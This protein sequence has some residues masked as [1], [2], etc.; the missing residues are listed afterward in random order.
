[1]AVRNEKVQTMHG[2]SYT[3]LYS[4]WIAMRQRCLC[5]TSGS[6]PEYGG[7]PEKPISICDEW[8]DSF[9]CFRG[10]AVKNGYSDSLTIERNNVNGN[11]EPS[12]CCWATWKKQANNRRNSFFITAFNKTQTL[13]LW[14]EECG[15]N[16]Q[17]LY[18]RLKNGWPVEK[19][20]TESIQVHRKN[21]A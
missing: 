3:R 15:I 5:P 4:I 9:E 17:T 18:S 6:F 20:L 8:R 14:S 12:N 21:T 11:Y 10:W 19:A 16:Y 1:M 13:E 7:R 2:G